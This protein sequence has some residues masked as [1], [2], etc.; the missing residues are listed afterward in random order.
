MVPAAQRYDIDLL[1]GRYCDVVS[2][3]V[4]AVFVEN[5]FDNIYERLDVFVL[6]VY[7]A[8]FIHVYLKDT[9]AK[10]KLQI[11]EI[12]L[13]GVSIYKALNDRG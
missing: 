6:V 7:C 3:V 11:F 8:I 1:C 5:K 12:C 13:R 10:M 9:R 2:V 4:L